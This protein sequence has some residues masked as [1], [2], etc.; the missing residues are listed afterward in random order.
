MANSDDDVIDS[1]DDAAGSDDLVMDDLDQKSTL[2]DVWRNNPMV[3]VAV[4]LG[5]LAVVVGGLVLFGGDEVATQQSMVAPGT[6]L[7]EAP[8]TNEVTQAY[9]DAVED[10]NNQMIENAIATGDSVI[11]VPIT[12]PSSTL[13]APDAQGAGEDPLAAWRQMQDQQQVQVADPAVAQANQDAELAR[14]QALNTLA[15]AMTA[16]MNQIIETRQPG[17][18]ESMTVT[19]GEQVSTLLGGGAGALA[20]LPGAAAAGLP[21]AAAA[22]AGLNGFLPVG[23]DPAAAAIQQQ[24]IKVLLS[25][26]TIEYAQLLLEANT[27]APGPVLAQIVTGPFAG[28]RVIGTFTNTDNYL[29]LN[30]NT[31]VKDKVNYPIN[32][33]AV[34]PETTL[35]GVVTDIDRRYFRRIVL[36]AAAR[37]IE[38]MGSAIAESGSQTT[39]TIDGDVAVEEDNTKIDTRQELYKGVEEGANE[40][41]DFLNE[42]GDE[43]EPMI[44]VKSG[45]PLGIFFTQPVTQTLDA[46][47]NIVQQGFPQQAGVNGQQ[48]QQPGYFPNGFVPFGAGVQGQPQ[49]GYPYGAP[50]GGTSTL[51]PATFGS[52]GFTGFNGYQPFGNQP[53]TGNTTTVTPTS[54]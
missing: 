36:P 44:R 10:Q 3:K 22:Q 11:P 34:D 25:A 20:G 1:F 37:F 32:A 2:G 30:F 19:G 23:T 50:T 53:N 47:G 17:R 4:V 33:V 28:G 8:G 13:P 15:N 38:G 18:I 45:T 51:N 21:G 5:V 29:V 9:A 12:P 41:S 52:T 48:Q 14:Q 31:L 7:K 43:V 46:N 35:P 42:E 49:G 24:T 39:V 6:D 26:G 54:N 16:Q 27:D 40:L